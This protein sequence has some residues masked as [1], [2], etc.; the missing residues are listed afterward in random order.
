MLGSR[1]VRGREVGILR[2]PELG[3][4]QGVQVSGFLRNG[5]GSYY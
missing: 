1:I 5:L 3:A 4:A 2:V